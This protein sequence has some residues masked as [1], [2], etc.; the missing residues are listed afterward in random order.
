MPAGCTMTRGE[1]GE[2]KEKK[3]IIKIPKQDKTALS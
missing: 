3:S 1:R 2:T